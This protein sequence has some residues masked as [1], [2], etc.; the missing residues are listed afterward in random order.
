MRCCLKYTKIS[1]FECVIADCCMF[2]CAEA[3]CIICRTCFSGAVNRKPRSKTQSCGSRDIDPCA[4]AKKAPAGAPLRATS[5]RRT[6]TIDASVQAALRRALA[7]RAT[8][9]ARFAVL[10]RALPERLEAGRRVDLRDGFAFFFAIFAISLSLS[11]LGSVLP[12]T[13]ESQLLAV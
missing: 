3:R 9:R 11:S 2:R 1:I 4:G 6:E 12:N 8:G 7:L 5:G 13:F 10:R